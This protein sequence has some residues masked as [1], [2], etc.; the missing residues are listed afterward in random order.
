MHATDAS[1]SA[2]AAFGNQPLAFTLKDITPTHPMIQGRGISVETA[3]HFGVGFF[4]GKGSMAG[5]VVFP[6][7]EVSRANGD[8][9]RQVM[10]VGYAGRTTLPIADTN[11][12][13]LF[14]KGLKKTFLYG[15][16][17]CDPAK[18]IILC[19]SPGPLWLAMNIIFQSRE[20]QGIRK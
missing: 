18:P 20:T 19:E 9:T 7:Y 13:W 11:P 2:D 15:L 4:P 12:K 5:R 14:G 17:R 16:E 3:K 1:N 10:L 6:F 8:G